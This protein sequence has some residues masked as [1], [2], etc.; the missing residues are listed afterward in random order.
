MIDKGLSERRSL[1]VAG[2][3]A[4]AYR[5]AMRPD[6]NVELRQ[7][8]LTLAQRHKRYGVGMIHLG[9]RGAAIGAHKAHFELEGIGLARQHAACQRPGRFHIQWINDVGGRRADQLGT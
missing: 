7:R 8:I 4:S 6:R 1:A 5:Y 3:S 2:M 9:P